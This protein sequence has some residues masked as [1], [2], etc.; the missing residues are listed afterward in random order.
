MA[1]FRRIAEMEDRYVGILVD[2]PGPKVR[3]ASFGEAAVPITGGSEVSLRLGS[4]QYGE[5]IEID[6]AGFLTDVEI[7]DRLS[8]GDGRVILEV[9]D[10]MATGSARVAHGGVLTGNPGFT[11]PR[12]AS[13]CGRPPTRT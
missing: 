2:L 12:T 11:F 8:M 1:N 10:W 4:G 6:Y 13:R 5:R 3:A 7:G 9:Q